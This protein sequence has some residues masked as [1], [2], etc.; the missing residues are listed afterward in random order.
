M[1]KNRSKLGGNKT[2]TRN[3]ALKAHRATEQAERLRNVT[4]WA[5]DWEERK[6]NPKVEQN[7]KGEMKTRRPNMTSKAIARRSRVLAS[8]LEQLELG[9]KVLS[10]KQLL[11]LPFEEYEALVQ[12]APLSE[13]KITVPLTPQDRMRVEEEISVLKKRGATVPKPVVVL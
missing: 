11:R 9:T 13:I 2:L 12:G 8:R 1:A 3:Q 5:E 4:K 10:T 7:T 6:R